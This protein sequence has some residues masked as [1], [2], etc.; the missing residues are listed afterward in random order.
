MMKLSFSLTSVWQ[1]G[2]DKK[3]SRIKP[4]ARR[5][6]RYA[7]HRLTESRG[8]K[9]AQA[10]ADLHF[11]ST[12]RRTADNRRPEAHTL[13]TASRFATKRRRSH[14]SSS[15][16]IVQGVSMAKR[17]ARRK[18]RDSAYEADNVHALFPSGGWSPL[19]RDRESRDR[20]YVKN[21]R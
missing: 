9:G 10:G 17:S 12:D 16:V 7:F 14:A 1:P 13:T 6:F 4:H 19:D 5:F 8:P 20:K 11:A 21:I 18:Y 2:T 3:S 15:S